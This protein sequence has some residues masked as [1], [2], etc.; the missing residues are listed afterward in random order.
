[1]L[2]VGVAVVEAG[3]ERAMAI[4][5]LVG[6]VGVGQVPRRA[7]GEDAVDVA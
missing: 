4:A 7:E 1:M 6:R 2:A 3:D 5:P